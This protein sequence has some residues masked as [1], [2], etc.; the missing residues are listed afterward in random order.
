MSLFSL[1]PR[2][3]LVFSLLGTVALGMTGCQKGETLYPVKGKVVLDNEPLKA[4]LVTYVP[5]GAKDTKAKSPTGQIQSD[6]TYSLMTDGRS[7]APAGKYKVMIATT[8]PGMGG[9]VEVDPK[10]P[11][12][13]APLNPQGQ[14][15]EINEKYKS[16][17][18]TDLTKEVSPTASAGAYDLQLSR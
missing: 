3:T 15:P 16:A 1:S 5:D 2:W 7:G 8:T 4:G 9:P 11:P 18:T 14:G 10:K 6:G 12:Q 17:S 13:L